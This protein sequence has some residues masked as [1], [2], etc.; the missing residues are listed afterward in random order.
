[1]L[2]V[3]NV[4]LRYG[5]RTLF[6]EVNMKFTH[7]NCYGVI[8]ANGAGKSTFL[9]I[10]SGEI[11]PMTGDIS[12]GPGERM[13]VLKQNH[14]EFD[15]C[16]VLNTVLMGNKKLWDL[17]QEKD[18]LYAKEDF[19]DKDGE[20]AAE[21]ETLFAE[22][23]GWNA[24]S[25]AANLLSGLGVKE[26]MHYTLMSELSGKDK[27]RVLLAQALFG[28][29][30]ILLLDE[31]TNDLD[32][33]TIRALEDALESFAGCAVVISHDRW[34]L[35]RVAT[36]ILAFEDDGKLVWHEGNYGDYLE[37]RRRRLGEDSDTPRRP[38]YRR[39]TR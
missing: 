36:H 20:K 37:A 14:F 16:T 25:D 10:L 9:K 2:N 18:A 4:S 38:K 34:F 22:M 5:K 29:P 39:L 13:S 12:M 30:E 7:G 23:D 35:D 6:E 8:G 33:N 24:E 32:V 27:V 11:E 31:P 17:M 26:D 1:M 28:N 15:G 19:S 21:L 3:S